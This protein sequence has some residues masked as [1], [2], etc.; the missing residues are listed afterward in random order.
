MMGSTYSVEGNRED[1]MAIWKICNEA[2]RLVVFT[3]KY[4]SYHCHPGR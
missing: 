2:V 3:L 1:I 4:N